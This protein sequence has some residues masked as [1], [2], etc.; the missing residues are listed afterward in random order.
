[1]AKTSFQ[2]DK[3]RVYAVKNIVYVTKHLLYPI[4]L[5]LRYG[6]FAVSQIGLISFGPSLVHMTSSIT[7]QGTSDTPSFQN[8]MKNWVSS[9]LI[10]SQGTDIY[11]DSLLDI[12]LFSTINIFFHGATAPSGPGP[13][14][15][16]GFTI[17]LRHTTLGRTPLDE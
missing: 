5:Y 12:D 7:Y 14:Y 1:M 9:F 11:P 6:K 17:T 10:P 4:L 2:K 13:P 15:Y 8:K 3:Y 16:R